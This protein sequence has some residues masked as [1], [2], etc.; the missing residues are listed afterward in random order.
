MKK[1]K[2]ISIGVL[3]ILALIGAKSVYSVF[4][5]DEKVELEK[6]LVSIQRS[7]NTMTE[8]EEY[9]KGRFESLSME[10]YTENTLW[11]K[12]KKEREFQDGRKHD[13]ICTLARLKNRDGE[14]V[15]DAT[16]KEC[17]EV[18]PIAGN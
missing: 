14:E 13:K 10:S 12:A 11:L 2:K 4:S 15:M 8:S 1:L 6:D 16:K 17:P 5:Y 3:V 9:H 7:I 18:F